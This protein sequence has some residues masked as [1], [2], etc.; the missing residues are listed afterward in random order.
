LYIVYSYNTDKVGWIIVAIVLEGAGVV[1]LLLVFV[2]LVRLVQALD[3][4]KNDRLRRSILFLRVIFL[5]GVALLIAGSSL[6]GQYNNASSLKL[7][8]KLAKA[9]YLIF[10]SVLAVLVAGAGVLWMKR[11]TLCADSNKVSC[12]IIFM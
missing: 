10:V 8:L 7:G 11:K 6:V 12:A 1:P 2:G 3:F 5:I 9:G 4:P